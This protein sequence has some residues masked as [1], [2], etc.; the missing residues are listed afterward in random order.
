MMEKIVKWDFEFELL[1]PNVSRIGGV[2]SAER[3]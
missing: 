2:P 3:Y 1:A